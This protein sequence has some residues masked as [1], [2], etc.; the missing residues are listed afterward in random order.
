MFFCVGNM[1]II[2]FGQQIVVYH[3]A[4]H[5]VGRADHIIGG[6]PGLHFGI[7]DF[8]G[9]EFVVNYP[10]TGFFF[11]GGEHIRIDILSPVV[12]HNFTVFP[13]LL[14]AT[15]G[16]DTHA[17]N[18]K[19]QRQSFAFHTFPPCCCICSFFF[20]CSA[21]VLL[22]RN[23]SRSTVTN[24]NVDREYISGLMPFFTSV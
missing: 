22:T 7:H 11:K 3:F 23:R 6:S 10:D 15:G 4:D 16:Q 12:Y 13:F 21:G 8:V 18:C 9:F 14:R 2:N 5:I 24:I 1:I 17:H 19:Q 20:F